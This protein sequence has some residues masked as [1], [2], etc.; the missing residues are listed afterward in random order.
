M[1]VK[2][3]LVSRN[4]KTGPIPVSTTS[5]DTCPSACP[6][7]DAGCYARTG[8][9]GMYWNRMS[10]ER[11]ADS[12]RTFL[13]AI[14]S[15]PAGQL[16]RHNQ[17][18]DLP[19]I[20]NNIDSKALGALVRANDG[21]RGFTYTHKP[22]TPANARAVARANANGFIINLSAN[23]LR[24][25]DSLAS[26]AIGPVVVVLPQT[27]ETN[28]TTPAGRKVVICPAVTHENVTCASCKLCARADREFVIG[29]PAHGTEKGKVDGIV[30]NL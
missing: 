16:W 3:T 7:K 13:G 22:M 5:K 12:W 19:G 17:A 14:R 28:T 4:K 18:G 20:G 11:A 10:K 2:L 23:N 24:E 8:P 26:L 30:S 6:F 27:Q 1:N 21:R 25:A 9:L 29:F 15:L